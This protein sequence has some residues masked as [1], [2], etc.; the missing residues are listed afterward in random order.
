MFSF[1]IR[2]AS[3]A[4]LFCCLMAQNQTNTQARVLTI[5]GTPI[6]GDKDAMG[7]EARFA[8]PTDVCDSLVSVFTAHNPASHAP[9]SVRFVLVHQREDLP[10]L[11]AVLQ[12][13]LLPDEKSCVVAD[14]QNNKIK[15]ITS[16]DWKL[17]GSGKVT[18][19]AGSRA[20]VC[21]INSPVKNST[22]FD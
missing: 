13:A 4:S 10:E 22:L 7:G 5:A 16:P 9:I 6:P 8:Y 17:P 3:I 19:L 1:G 20:L 11:S 21:S 12:V 14:S 18:T 15:L 2:L